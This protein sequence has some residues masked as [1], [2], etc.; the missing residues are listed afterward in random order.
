M[1]NRGIG[2]GWMALGLSALVAGCGGGG[3]LEIQGFAATGA[4]IAGADV[5]ARCPQGPELTGKTAADGTFS[6]ELARDQ[7]PPCIVRVSQG[8]TTLYSFATDKGRLNVT[9][10]TDLS[11]RRALGS[12]PA[13][14]PE[15]V[16]SGFDAARATLLR[17]GIGN[18]KAAIKAQVEALTGQAIAGDLFTST[19]KVGD[20]DDLVLDKL[21]ETLTTTGTSLSDIAI[22]AA[23]SRPLASRVMVFGDSLSDSGA[24]GLKFTVQGSAATGAGSSDIWVDRV[25]GSLQALRLCPHFDLTGS[26]ADTRAACTNYAVG[27]GRINNLGDPADPRSIP[28]QLQT[29]AL[30]RAS[31]SP[32]DVLLITGGGNDAADLAGAWLGATTPAGQQAF[33]GLLDSVLGAGSAAVLLGDGSNQNAPFLAGVSYMQTLAGNMAAAIQEHA[34]S[35]GA[36]RVVVMNVPDIALT[37]RFSA[38]LVGVTLQ[39][40]E[41]QAAA[42]KQVI[43]AWVDTFNA[44]LANHFLNNSKVAVLDFNTVFRAQVADPIAS[45]FSDSSSTACPPTGTDGSGLPTYNFQTC[46]AAALSAQSGKPSADW[47]TTYMFSDGFHPTP[48]AHAK[49]AEEAA[50]V[51]TARGWN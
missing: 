17:Q 47:W 45:G 18:A 13:A 7:G 40:N 35:K 31:Y 27:G 42:V 1:F 20:P 29:A 4:A 46:T 23:Q 12:G 44:S 10:L 25:A 19:F 36:E 50:K 41:A 37:P 5:T 16:F 14:D 21:Q 48:L 33:A 43:Q 30:S 6:L 34:L 11:V 24:F 2:A 26:P 51:L 9:P 22:A 49:A 32:S 39:T 8:G 38:V 3:S 28:L 15:A